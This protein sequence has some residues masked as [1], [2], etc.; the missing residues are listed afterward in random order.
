MNEIEARTTQTHGCEVDFGRIARV[1]GRYRPPFPR[2][3]F[4]RLIELGVGEPGQRV[5][6]IGTGTGHMARAFS[7]RSCLVTG[8]DKSAAL[9]TQAVRETEEEGGAV[10]YIQAPAEDTGLPEETYGAVTACQCWGWFDKPAAAR[11]AFRLL[12]PGGML[13]IVTYDWVTRAGGPAEA[14]EELIVQFNPNW[15][16]VGGTGLHPDYLMDLTPAGFAD[17]ET[18]SFDVDV[19][20]SR[21]SWR[22]RVRASAGVAASLEAETVARFDDALR[23]VLE[24]RYPAEPLHILHRIFACVARKPGWDGE[25]TIDT[26]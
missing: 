23:I 19:P 1:Y 3:L 17:I 22:G 25:Q 26:F 5:L 4:E 6:D 8:L 11:E 10:K 12:K 2:V 24:D 14:A 20:F 15:V 21:E 16:S 9:I 13:A 7:R 18:F